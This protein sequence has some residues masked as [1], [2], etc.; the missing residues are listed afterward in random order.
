[1]YGEQSVGAVAGLAAQAKILFPAL[2]AVGDTVTF[3]GTTFTFGTDFFGHNTLTNTGAALFTDRDKAAL[4]S[5]LANKIRSQNGLGFTAYAEGPV[6]WLVA[7]LVG[8]DPNA[9]T[10]STTN[11]SAF[12][13]PATF[14]GGA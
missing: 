13:V 4:A 5:N 8:T 14:S 12:T 7:L 1:M 3:N 2:P 9:W 6:L 10:C 11:S